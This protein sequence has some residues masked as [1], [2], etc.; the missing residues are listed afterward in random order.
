MNAQ[1]SAAIS[2]CEEVT[3]LRAR[4]FHY[5]L[6]LTPPDRRWAMYAV[7]AWMRQADDLA[8]TVI[9]RLGQ[10]D[11]AR[12]LAGGAMDRGAAVDEG[13]VDVEHGEGSHEPVIS[14]C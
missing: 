1:L 8:D 14:C 4:N 7:Y 5:G 10:A 11:V 9:V 12:G 13:A 3:R 2:K 6:R